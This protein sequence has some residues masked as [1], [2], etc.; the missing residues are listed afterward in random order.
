[1]TAHHRGKNRP[2]AGISATKRLPHAARLL[3]TAQI[4]LHNFRHVV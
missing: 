3:S 2:P 1:V 4:T